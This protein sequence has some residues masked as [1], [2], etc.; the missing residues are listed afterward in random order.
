MN[1][2]SYE[3]QQGAE[4]AAA[5]QGF[6]QTDYPPTLPDQGRIFLL[7]TCDGGICAMPIGSVYLNSNQL[8]WQRE[9]NAVSANPVLKRVIPLPTLQLCFHKALNVGSVALTDLPCHVRHGQAVCLMP[10]LADVLTMQGRTITLTKPVLMARLTAFR[11]SLERHS[12][13]TAEPVRRSARRQARATQAGDV[14]FRGTHAAACTLRRLDAAC[15]QVTRPAAQHAPLAKRGTAVLAR[16][17]SDSAD[18]Q[19]G[20]SLWAEMASLAANRASVDFPATVKTDVR[21]V[22]PLVG[23]E[24]V[25]AS[26]ATPT[27][28]RL[29]T[30]GTA[31]LVLSGPPPPHR[32]RAAQGRHRSAAQGLTTLCTSTW[33]ALA[34]PRC[35]RIRLHLELIPPVPCPRLFPQRGGTSIVPSSR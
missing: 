35:A 9:V 22:R 3:V 15:D 2:T 34:R 32:A 6:G 11:L 21:R 24:A 33:R 23:E 27:R 4:L 5:Y 17:G 13:T 19:Q 29:S 7:V 10:C 12:T 31:V 14:V 26:T 30:I 1:V 20:P 8:L 28:Q 18:P 25:S 16:W